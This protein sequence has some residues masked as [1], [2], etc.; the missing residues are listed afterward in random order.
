MGYLQIFYIINWLVITM[1]AVGTL[2]IVLRWPANKARPWFTLF[3]LILVLTG[4][5]SCCMRLI[6]HYAD[7]DFWDKFRESLNQLSIL[8][9]SIGTVGYVFLM[10]GLI[11]LGKLLRESKRKTPTE[12]DQWEN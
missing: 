11:Q 7:R 10:I 3:L 2:V 8:I 4:L 12:I 1:I 6:Y 9:S 5:Y